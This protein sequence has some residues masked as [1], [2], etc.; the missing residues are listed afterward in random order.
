MEKFSKKYKDIILFM[1]IY[2]FICFLAFFQEIS[3]IYVML[4][5]NVLLAVL[6]LLFI[7]KAEVGMKSDKTIY[8]ILWMVAWILFFPNSVYMI[9]DFIHISG[10]KF[11]WIEEVRKYSMDRPVVYGN[12]ILIWIKLLIIGVG[13]LFSLLVGLES[14]YIFEQN[15]KVMT[16]KKTSILTVLIVSLLS[17]IGVY[18]G[19]FLRFN[20][21][22][23]FFNPVQLLKEV[24]TVINTFA[25]QFISVFT[26]F[27]IVCYMV[28]R[29]FR[30]IALC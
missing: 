4:S 8:S 26:V 18:I 10:D 17:A 3:F 15:M 2:W 5:W 25:M 13:F 20:S 7:H 27:I 30:K 29:I 23:I 9:T 6:P 14:L 11:M 19:R 16:S 21:W 12:D 28:Y 24:T 1:L 22:D